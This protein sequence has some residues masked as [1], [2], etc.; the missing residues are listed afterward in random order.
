M[1]E[2]CLY[3]FIVVEIVVLIE[4]GEFLLGLCLLGECDLVECLGVSWVMVCEV[5]IVLEVQGL[6]IIKIGL[7][8]YVKV[9]LLQVLG[10]L[11]DV[12]VFDFIV[13]CVV[14]EVEVVVMVVSCIIDEELQDLVGLIVVMVDLVLGEVVVSEVDWQF[15]LFIVCIVGN[16][17]VEYCVQLI[18]WMCNELLCVKQVYVN[19]C[20]NDDDICDEEYIVIFDV[21]CQCDLVVVWLVMCNYFQWLFE[22]MLEVIENEVF[23]EIWW[24]IQ[25][26]CECFMVVIGLQ[27]W[28]WVEGLFVLVLF[29]FDQL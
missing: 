16:L 8:V 19:V 17:V 4:K 25:Q 27:V 11:L 9:C 18:W 2:F 23:V 10:V 28:C 12:L 29:F 1:F 13:V 5:E 15:Y 6:I 14:I 3:Q 7:G 21:L 26:D 20:Y 24:C 22:L